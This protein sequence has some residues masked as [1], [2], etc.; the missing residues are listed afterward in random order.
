MT[1]KPRQR[2]ELNNKKRLEVGFRRDLLALFEQ[3]R[4]RNAQEL[5]DMGEITGMSHADRIRLKEIVEGHYQKVVSKFKNTVRKTNNN[6]KFVPEDDLEFKNDA[7]LINSV[8]E[9]FLAFESQ[10]RTNIIIETTESRLAVSV[11]AATAKMAEELGREPATVSYTHLT[12]P[13]IYSV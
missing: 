6:L 7:D 11:T 1:I 9:S 2:I 8:V 3:I 4:N 10:V 13:T 12:L 5:A